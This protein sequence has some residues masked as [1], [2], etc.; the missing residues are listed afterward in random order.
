[1]RITEIEAWQ[2]NISLKAPYTIAYATIDKAENIFLRITTNTGLTAFGCAAPDEKVT[3]ESARA[4]LTDL[5]DIAAPVLKGADPLRPSRL[6]HLLKKQ[7]L[8]DRPGAMAAVDMALTD[9]LGK[10]AGLPAWKLLGGFRDRI[11]TSVTIGILPV[12]DT[13]AQAKAFVEQGFSC[14]KLKGGL[15]VDLDVERLIKVREAVGPN[16]EL[17]FDANQGYSF[18]QSVDFVNRTKPA[19]LELLEQPTPQGEYDLLGR[20]TSGVDIPIMADES[21]LTLRDAFRLARRDL[22]DMVNIKLMKV[23]GIAEALRIEAIARVARLEIMVGC[24]DESA[25]AIAAGLAF[26]LS[27]STIAYADLDGH[28]DLIDDPADGAVILRQGVLYPSN[29]PGLG[30]NPVG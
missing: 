27:R 23:G 15:D 8:I 29:Q 7:G 17:R 4:V 14:L 13:V 21:L 12:K 1:M 11:K 19:K 18:D 26:A 6:L 5:Q 30:K 9:L 16:V 24:M 3:G 22:A 28:F 10:V 25:L 2:V 20:V